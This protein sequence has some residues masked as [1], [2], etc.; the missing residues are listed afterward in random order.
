MQSRM[1]SFVNLGKEILR[2]S[3][4][5]SKVKLTFIAIVTDIDSYFCTC[6]DGTRQQLVTTHLQPRTASPRE[7]VLPG[8]ELR[9]SLPLPPGQLLR[10]PGESCDLTLTRPL[11]VGSTPACFPPDVSTR[12]RRCSLAPT[13]NKVSSY[14]SVFTHVKQ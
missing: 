4:H 6:R 14:K 13:H 7:L 12:F 3:T 1:D 8:E 5:N 11:P 2:P 9:V 10:L